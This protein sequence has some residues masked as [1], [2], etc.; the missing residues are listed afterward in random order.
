MLPARERLSSREL[1][2]FGIREL[3]QGL[4]VA[5]TISYLYK[6]G[7]VEPLHASS[8][9]HPIVLDEE[10]SR[11]R[12]V[13]ADC[14]VGVNVLS[15]DGH[16]YYLKS[17]G[18][19]HLLEPANVAIAVSL[20]DKLKPLE[21]PEAFDK[22]DILGLMAGYKDD[23]S[24]V[25]NELK[26]ALVIPINAMIHHARGV[27]IN[28]RDYIRQADGKQMVDQWLRPLC[29]I[30]LSDQDPAGRLVDR[31]T[32]RLALSAPWARFDYSYLRLH[33]NLHEVES[34]AVI[35]GFGAEQPGKLRID[36]MQPHNAEATKEWLDIHVSPALA[37]LALTLAGEPKAG[38]VTVV[39]AGS[40][41]GGLLAQV[42]H[43]FEGNPGQLT[44]VHSDI[45]RETRKPAQELF[46][47]K[48]I[49][50][51]IEWHIGDLM[52]RSHLAELKQLVEQKT[53]PGLV[54][55]CMNYILQEFGDE[56]IDEFLESFRS[57]LGDWLFAITENWTLGLKNAGYYGQ[58]VPFLA[59]HGYSGQNLQRRE[60]FL[61]RLG[62]YG[63]LRPEFLTAKESELVHID[64]PDPEHPMDKDKRIITNSTL[65]VQCQ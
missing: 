65:V 40:G 12:R 21:D 28:T 23:L 24:G 57:V 19:A 15:L 13:A 60:A 32:K 50:A 58:D 48:G 53:K 47:S 25:P 4:V 37:E 49:D 52:N 62:G 11:I 64:I 2:K 9:D 31:F 1:I 33:R 27:G 59:L 8:L 10:S 3:G 51:Q 6:A 22:Q 20:M 30:Y 36:R 5:S 18:K 39:D 63:F 45:D 56:Q 14:M 29:E 26:G 35:Y 16:G 38:N 17:G 61:K 34:G 7:L 54:L 41:A 42:A 55:F 44:I 43:A 46:A